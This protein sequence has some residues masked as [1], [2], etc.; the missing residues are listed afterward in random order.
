MARNGVAQPVIGSARELYRILA[1]HLLGCGRGVGEH[2]HVDS[3]GV[4]FLDAQSVE[5]LE[6]APDRGRTRALH[7]AEFGHNGC[8]AIM[9]LQRDDER[10]ACGHAPHPFLGSPAIAWIS[11]I[12]SGQASSFTPISV[13]A[14]NGS[15]R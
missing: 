6:A 3:G 13:I 8:V 11:T 10:L 2:L 7:D 4:H 1:L 15:L 9:L 12:K 5:I 14:G